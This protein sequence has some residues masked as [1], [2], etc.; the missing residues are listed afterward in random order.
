MIQEFSDGHN[1]IV[2]KL[3]KDGIFVKLNELAKS[4]NKNVDDFFALP[5]VKELLDEVEADY[6]LPS[7]VLETEELNDQSI[8]WA[9]QD[10]AIQFAYWLNPALEICLR[11]CIKDFLATPVAR[12][13]IK[14]RLIGQIDEGLFQLILESNYDRSVISESN[15]SLFESFIKSAFE[16]QFKAEPG[17][18]MRH[19]DTDTVAK[20]V[21]IDATIMM[22]ILKRKGIIYDCGGTWLLDKL[23]L[24]KNYSYTESDIIKN[25]FG[26]LLA[27]IHTDWTMEG[28]K[29][30][31]DLLKD[32]A[33]VNLLRVKGKEASKEAA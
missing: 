30:V 19:M 15:P 31:I 5:I 14:N 17:K 9:R 10:Y 28:A 32:D 13:N 12:F 22:D 8:T 24:N 26:E 7:I 4:Q 11:K 21:G 6:D 23:F 25:E 33:D 16:N 3:T 1:K 20:A 29:F 18:Y 27:G 2:L